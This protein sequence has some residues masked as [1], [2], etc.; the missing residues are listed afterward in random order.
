MCGQRSHFIRFGGCSYKCTWC[1]SMHAVD[2][3]QIKANA[4]WLSSDAILQRL[5]HLPYSTWV[6][7][8]G[9]DPAMWQ[10]GTLVAKLRRDG[11]LVAVETQ[12]HLAPDWLIA[13]NMVTVS[14]K[15]PSSGMADKFDWSI[16]ET[17][18]NMFEVGQ[19]IIKV[20]VFDKDDLAFVKE[21]QANSSPGVQFYISVGTK[22]YET[23]TETQYQ[24]LERM[25]KITELV[26]QDD[27]L[28]SVTILPQMH[29]L[30]WGTKLGV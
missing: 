18:A 16:L 8:S 2:P 29:V 26:L 14:P 11:F 5:R 1:D 12:G 24:I 7:L 30:T 27:Q 22:H 15:G 9:G 13:C 23:D 6:T 21:L 20:V 10:L 19:W 17:Y 28:D 3:E 4:D 25:R